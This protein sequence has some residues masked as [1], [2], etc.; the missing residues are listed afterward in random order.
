MEGFAV[1]FSFYKVEV[2]VT[3]HRGGWVEE[4][5]EQITLPLGVLPVT[6]DT[7]LI[8]T[9]TA[10][11]YISF[12]FAFRG[13]SSEILTV[14]SFYSTHDSQGRQTRRQETWVLSS[15][16]SLAE[17]SALARPVSSLHH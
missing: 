5:L 17:G 8:R 1:M 7:K 13:I 11:F 2:G 10:P 6:Q 3:E 15:H 16:R 4:C 9:M 12:H 14:L